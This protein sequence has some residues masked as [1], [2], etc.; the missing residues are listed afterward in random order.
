MW[1]IFLVG[2]LNTEQYLNQYIGSPD[3]YLWGFM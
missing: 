2:A 1:S 3:F